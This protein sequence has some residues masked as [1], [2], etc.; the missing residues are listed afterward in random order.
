MVLYY[1]LDGVYYPSDG[2]ARASVDE[3]AAVR[4]GPLEREHV[5]VRVGVRVRVRV[6]VT[7]SV[8]QEG[9]ATRY[10]RPL[11]LT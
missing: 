6:R 11:F 1:P 5:R 10:A 3:E 7:A 4:L 2:V 9:A 8:S